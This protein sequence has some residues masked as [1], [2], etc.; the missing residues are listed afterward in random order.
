MEYQINK[1]NIQMNELVSNTTA[2]Q[3]I[4]LDYMLP[5]YCADVFKV[6]RV[7]MMPH[8]ISERIS[9][10]K[11]MVEGI[12]DIKVTYLGGEGNRMNCIEQ[13]KSFSKTV[14][15]KE[16]CSNGFASVRA[17]CDYVNCRAQNSRRL[18]I[19]GAITMTIMVYGSKALDVVSGSDMLHV[20]TKQLTACQKKMYGSKEFAIKDELQVGNG[21]PAIKE[22]LDYTASALVSDYKMISNKAICKGEL[23][24]HT[25][26]LAENSSAPEIIEHSIPISQIMD[27]E[28]VDEDY[29]CTCRFEVIKYDIDL[30]MDEDGNCNSF[31]VEIGIRAF[32]E[33]ACNQE[34][35]IVDDCY[36][37]AC[38][39]SN[40]MSRH[41][42][43]Q[44]CEVIEQ[45]SMQKHTVKLSDD[46][47]ASVYDVCCDVS[48][49]SCKTEDNK[50]YVLC[51]LLVKVLAC[52]NEGMPTSMDYT[53]PCEIAAA[54]IEDGMEI[55]FVPNIC[56]LSCAYNIL[57]PTELELRAELKISGIL[58]RKITVNLLTDVVLDEEHMK[59][60]TDDAAL[61]LYFAD[62]GEN[63]WGIAKRYNTSV[64]AI[65]EHNSIETET[66]TTRG[67]IFIP[68]VD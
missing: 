48:N 53:I 41:E 13:K 68:I 32:C 27:C 14:D 64:H 38:E 57:S 35:E 50:L 43:E 56:I 51:N 33:A 67:M 23:M 29:S 18:D 55:S 9:G 11:L 44:M 59:K 40:T 2:E 46:S 6:L 4:E 7:Q 24:L 25:L 5:D 58:Y 37:T 65:L 49:V 17:K 12:A 34:I 39:V 61:R 1:E 62:E 54:D 45:T 21:K 15:L 42:V 63:I 22:V 28:G 66:L 36:S 10:N 31:W 20:H 60:R 8:I 3:S 30:Q 52:D 16:D 26:Y 19:K 47:I